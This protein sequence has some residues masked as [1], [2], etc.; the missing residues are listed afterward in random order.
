MTKKQKNLIDFGKRYKVLEHEGGYILYDCE[1]KSKRANALYLGKFYINSDSEKYSFNGEFYASIDELISA[2]LEY[3]RTLPFDA[4]I[5]NPMYRKHFM[6]ECALN[7]YLSSLG[8]KNSNRSNNLYYLND[9]Y[10]QSI[11]TIKIETIEDT[12]S[13][14]ISRLIP[15]NNTW[16]E[17][18][19]TDLDSAI[20]AVNS[21]LAMYCITINT[22]T[23][24]VLNGLTTNM[25]SEI[26]D[27][28]FNVKDMCIYVEDAKKKTIEMLE[29]EL[30]RLKES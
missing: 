26:L 5:Y 6:I 29:S 28:T 7:D 3:N 30:K 16:T 15:N 4:E 11:C 20:G 13:G 25:A 18:D 21:I 14:K 9:T 22:I 2:M 10:G 24:R 1:K 8:F 23:M 12:A 27:K 17:S 19:F